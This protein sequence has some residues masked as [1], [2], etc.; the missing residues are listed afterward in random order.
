[1]SAIAL[2]QRRP[3]CGWC[4][5]NAFLVNSVETIRRGPHADSSGSGT[6]NVFREPF[7]MIEV[8]LEHRLML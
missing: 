2:T 6:V 5:I 3:K 4:S 1:M 7:R 8:R